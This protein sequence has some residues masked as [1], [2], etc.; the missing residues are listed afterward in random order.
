MVIRSISE[1]LLVSGALVLFAGSS[2]PETISESVHVFSGD[3]NGVLIERGG[4]KL[5]VYGD[6]VDE[7]KEAET[8]LITHFRRDVVWAAHSLV[9]KGS[10][11]VLPSGEKA[12]LTKGDSI[13][14]SMTSTRFHDYNCQTSKIG[15]TPFERCRFVNG[16]EKFKWQDT[17]FK[18]LNTPGYTRG[19]ISYIAVI[20]GKKIAFTGDLLYGEG[21][22]FDLYSF[23]DSLRDIG[24]YHGYATRLGQLVSSL[25]KIAGEN[26]DI[27]IPSRGPVI[28][29][30]GPAIQNLIGQIHSLYANYLS[31]SAYRWYYPKRMK[32]MSDH[33]LGIPGTN[34][35]MPYPSVIKQ[36]TPLWFKAYSNSRLVLSE[37][38]SAFLIDCGSRS[39]L[40]KLLEMKKTGKLKSID[41]IFITHYHDDHTNFIN[42]VVK[43][44]HCPVYVT[45]E[46][47]DILE[48]PGSY[49]MPCLTTEAINGLVIMNDRQQMQWK[50]FNLTFYFFPGQTLY[51]DAVLFEKRGGETV[52]F[53]GDSFTPSGIDDYCLLN[54][55]LYQHEKGYFYC[56]DILNELPEN[57]LLCNQHVEPL[58]TFSHLQLDHL[59]NTLAERAA[60]LKN[61]LPWDNL[62]YGLDEQWAMIYPYWQKA[63]PGQSL[64]LS[65][66]ISNHSEKEK[67]FNV[68]LNLPEGIKTVKANKSVKIDPFS[69]G[70]IKFNLLI[71]KNIKEGRSLITTDIGADGRLLHEWSEALIEIEH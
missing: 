66:R 55:N 8:V 42:A 11:A 22:I 61:L 69:D 12:Y 68:N 63:I 13:W 52:F 71:Q 43:E 41:G 19:S 1:I 62:D 59:K 10:L 35:F 54:R 3:I 23:Q 60:I 6:P 26:P 70:E 44:F 33:V 32:T 49:N 67:T 39:A 9:K 18:I 50:D 36:E 47:K 40:E 58:F 16:G 27:I 48:N 37:D 31:V 57:M 46:L 64:A 2:N 51:H 20:D 17:E 34:D 15:I 5:V 7:I 45:K 29:D 25:K 30:P 28:K 38:S 21:K 56:L 24:G 4:K 53:I 65:V 14:R